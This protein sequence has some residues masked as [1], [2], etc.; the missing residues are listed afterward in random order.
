[1]VDKE[2][3][4]DIAALKSEN[5][6][7]EKIVSALKKR[8]KQTVRDT[9]SSFSLFE[10]HILLQSELDQE[11]FLK[12]QAETAAKAKADF[13]ANMSHEIRTPM[14]GVIGMTDLLLDT[15]LTS[16]QWELASI[17]KESAT[18]LL[19]IIN[20]I[21]DFSKIEANKLQLDYQ[22][23]NLPKLLES[24]DKLL[25]VSLKQK[26]LSFLIEYDSRVPEILY[27]DSDRL[28]QIILNL[29]SNAIKFTPIGGAIVLQ[30]HLELQHE[31][32][33]E[34]MFAVTDTGIGIATEQQTKIFEAFS[35]ADASVTR[36]YGGTGLG[37]AISSRLAK[38]MG[39]DIT[40]SS[41]PSVG[42]IFSFCAVF[43]RKDIEATLEQDKTTSE[44][45]MNSVSAEILLVEDNQVNQKLA[46]RILE[47]AGF[48][49]TT[50]DNG[51]KAVEQSEKSDFDL[52]LMDIQMPVMDGTAATR[53]IRSSKNRN[54]SVPII[55]LTAHAMSGD[56]EKYLSQGMDSYLTKPVNANALIKEVQRFIGTCDRPDDDI[57]S[58]S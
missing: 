23:F 16:E 8:V 50:V 11:K 49:V 40:L 56:R 54:A 37:L 35:Q 19:T 12:E 21:L 42:S 51:Q 52:I 20:D 47:K 29:T 43:P 48:S 6:K 17:V 30:V 44:D 38:L 57:K 4:D 45:P 3:A 55:A 53:A 58:N 7:L 18:A 14:N 10:S 46:R 33:Y 9:G 2:S 5:E 25:S 36:K 13:L 32:H 28:R 39:G 22:H 24:I 41:I 27:G 26:K 1:M 31:K 34:V 15:E